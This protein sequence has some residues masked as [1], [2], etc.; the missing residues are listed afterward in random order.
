MYNYDIY[1]VYDKLINSFYLNFKELS[2]FIYADS[3]NK[4]P[5]NTIQ[6]LTHTMH[7][8]LS[9]KRDVECL[10]KTV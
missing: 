7:H 1:I 9:I 2:T 10:Q 8:L 5:K 6:S 3:G 4:D